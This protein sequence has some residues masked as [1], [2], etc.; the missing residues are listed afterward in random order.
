MTDIRNEK[1]EVVCD[2]NLNDNCKGTYSISRRAVDKNKYRNNGKVICLPCSRYVKT[3]GRNNG[4]TKYKNLNDNFFS[5]V[6]TEAKAYLLGWIASDGSITKGSIQIA[7]NNKD[8]ETLVLI[9]NIICPDLPLYDMHGLLGFTICSKQI[10]NDVC[11]LLNIQ[12]GKKSDLVCFPMELTSEL[13]WAFIRGYFDGDGTISNIMSDGLQCAISSQSV[14]MRQSIY[15]FVNIP[16]WCTEPGKEVGWSGNNALDFLSKIYD[17]SKYFLLR[18]YDLYI[19]WCTW[20]PGL[21]GANNSG[22]GLSIKWMKS[23]PA[24]VTP[25]KAHASD[26]GYDLTIIRKAKEFGNVT[27]Y[28][29]GIKVQPDFGW[30]IDVVPRSSISKTGYVMA[31]SI[32]IIDRTY[33]GEIFIAL[34]KVDPD[35][36]ELELPCRIAQ[37]IPRPIVHSQL[38]QVD[39][40]EESSRFDGGFGSTGVK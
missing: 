16:G 29:T 39:E 2:F 19:D 5:T 3:S 22:K 28:G 30:Y 32:G 4:N 9:R 8:F 36:F 23:D 11:K 24:A 27:L 37:M 15:D 13:K 17:G 18:K 10:V 35:A 34:I 21:S 6:D 12:P 20:V 31:N 38:Y 7:I 26:S 14:L 33:K 40:L 25:S 1:L